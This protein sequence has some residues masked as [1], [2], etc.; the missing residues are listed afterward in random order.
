MSRP[1]FD[2]SL[3][4]LVYRYR[5]LRYRERP[6][7]RVGVA[8]GATVPAWVLRVVSGAAVVGA[9]ALATSR[10]ALGLVPGL[11][12][13]AALAG[14]ML[15]VPSALVG[16]FVTVTVGVALVFSDHA[17]LDP[18]VTG[19]MPLAYLCV[20]LGGLCSLTRWEGR[21]QIAALTRGWRRDL[22]V[23]A[24][25]EAL[26]GV[27]WLTAGAPALIVTAAGAAALVILTWLAAARIRP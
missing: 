7:P 12:V 1:E 10:G 18:A 24:A 27:A 26:A 23:V 25:A 6:L 17:P 9:V 16:W 13:G 11:L 2:S 15:A 20:R 22:A 14:W 4:S 21:V 19:L 5:A 8:G 3:R